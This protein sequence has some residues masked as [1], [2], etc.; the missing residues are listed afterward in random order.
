MKKNL[1]MHDILDRAKQNLDLDSDNQLALWL[2]VTR[3]LIS[4]WRLT[5]GKHMP[6]DDTLE[7]L[8]FAARLKPQDI[9]NAVYAQKIKALERKIAAVAI[10]F[11]IAFPLA[12]GRNAYA[13][14]SGT[15]DIINIHYTNYRRRLASWISGLN[16]LLTQAFR[17]LFTITNSSNN[18][19]TGLSWMITS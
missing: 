8:A 9:R 1:T 17:G 12:A 18:D 6:E 4:K 11:L 15:F 3:Q 7:K 14:E 2:G 19:N 5:D 10:F 13:M 16:A